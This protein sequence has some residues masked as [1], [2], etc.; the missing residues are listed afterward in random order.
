LTITNGYCTLAEFL[1]YL[2]ESGVD[3]ADDAVAEQIIGA[4]SRFI[5]RE[6]GRTFFPRTE[7]R[8]FDTPTDRELKL[9]DDLISI[10][11]L[12][13]G[14][15]AVIAASEYVLWPANVSPK[16]A[17]RLKAGST[18]NWELDSNSNREQVISVAG[19]WGYFAAVPDDIKLNCL[20]IAR[21]AYHRRS[22]QTAEAAARLT[23]SGLVIEPADVPSQ[24]LR[25]IRSYARRT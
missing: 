7:T 12:T 23:Q 4:A 3:T 22:G 25:N 16:R 2:K 24:V 10:T 11:T 5:D 14:D 9:D 20:E 19:S 6:A 13:N 21:E 8:K 15:G 18:V 1:A 17:I